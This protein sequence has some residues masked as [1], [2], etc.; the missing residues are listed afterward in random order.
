MITPPAQVARGVAVALLGQRLRGLTVDHAAGVEHHVRQ[1]DVGRHV[2]EE[3]GL[4]LSRD[5]LERR[6]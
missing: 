2:R 1:Q 6:R 4:Q 3:R 5:A